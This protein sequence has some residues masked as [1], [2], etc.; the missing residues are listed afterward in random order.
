[1]DTHIY[2]LPLIT[3]FCMWIVYIT[4]LMY[5]CI[6]ML[7]LL[8]LEVLQ[9]NCTK[10][11][12]YKIFSI[13]GCR[14][15]TSLW[16][17]QRFWC[18]CCKSQGRLSHLLNFFNFILV[19]LV[20]IKWPIKSANIQYLNFL[21]LIACESVIYDY[22]YYVYPLHTTCEYLLNFCLMLD[23]TKNKSLKER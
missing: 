9:I 4:S 10:V 1:M 7:E 18:H 11:L 5:R 12:S 20:H 21:V 8:I 3:L 17:I 13:A 2:L 16:H 14:W 6:F 23:N 15:K 22:C 19:L